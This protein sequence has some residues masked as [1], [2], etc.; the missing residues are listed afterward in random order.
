[1]T[2]QKLI[3]KSLPFFFHIN[4]ARKSMTR[5]IPAINTTEYSYPKGA[6]K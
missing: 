6:L 5:T 3:E 4:L 1:M 2:R